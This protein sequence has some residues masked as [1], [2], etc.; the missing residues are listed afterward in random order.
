MSPEPRTVQR[1]NNLSTVL[2]LLQIKN[3]AL[4]CWK[5]RFLR[6][7][8]IITR[9]IMDGDHLGLTHQRKRCRTCILPKKLRMEIA[10]NLGDIYAIHRTKPYQ[11][12]P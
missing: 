9:E 3:G 10:N 11:I 6:L 1:A 8:I 12:C 5:K 4:Q 7:Q 2:T